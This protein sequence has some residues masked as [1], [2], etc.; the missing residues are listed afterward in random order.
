MQQNRPN[1][2]A[3][4][5]R[6]RLVWRRTHNCQPQRCLRSGRACQRPLH[7]PKLG[8]YRAIDSG[9]RKAVLICQAA[10][11]RLVVRV[12]HHFLITFPL[13]N[14]SV[15][16]GSE[17]KLSRAG[18][19]CFLEQRN[20]CNPAPDRAP[21]GPKGESIQRHCFSSQPLRTCKE[22]VE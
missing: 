15:R 8:K 19:K 12:L 3:R 18:L 2:R 4:D 11:S 21:M 7:S 10:K 20:A 17:K 5:H 9:P 14:C 6:Q 16:R 13:Q 1:R 22:A